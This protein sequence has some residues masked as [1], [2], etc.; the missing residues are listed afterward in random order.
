MESFP[1]LPFGIAAAAVFLC[2]SLAAQPAH[3]WS[4]ILQPWKHPGPAVQAGQSPFLLGQQA[5]PHSTDVQFLSSRQMTAADRAIVANSRAAIAARAAFVDFQLNH[6]PWEV[7]QIACRALPN[8]LF[9]RYTRNNGARDLS[10][11]SVSIP[12]NGRGRL[13][14]IPV[15]RRGYSLFSPAP[16][17]NG[18]IAAFNQIRSEDGRNPK[19]GWLET[20][21]CYAA[22]A[23]ADPSVGQLTGDAV[24]ND[25]APPLAEMQV[26]LDGGAVVR[27]TDQASLPHPSLWS[28]NF[29]PSGHLL[30]VTREPAVLNS[31]WIVPQGWKPAVKTNPAPSVRP[32]G[33]D[34]SETKDPATPSNR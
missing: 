23:G 34:Q 25:P 33:S 2:T 30:K 22:L 4:T 10:V 19:T 13:R 24:V 31:H 11:F 21:L 12:R 14:V 27:F 15:L 6:G 20:S 1:K 17:N 8:H 16:S 5:P 29:S 18:T 7:Q 3:R 28:L 9:L 32:D 26:L